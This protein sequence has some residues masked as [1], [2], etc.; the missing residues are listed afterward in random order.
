MCVHIYNTCMKVYVHDVHFYLQCTVHNV[1]LVL[2]CPAWVGVISERGGGVPVV[3]LL[4]I[5][6]VS[7]CCITSEFIP[8]TLW[9]MHEHQ[10]GS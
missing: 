8:N 10:K 6:P 9:N 3:I 2:M 7:R 1:P 5:S 4:M